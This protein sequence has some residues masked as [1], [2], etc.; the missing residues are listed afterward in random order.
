MFRARCP[1]LCVLLPILSRPALIQ[2]RVVPAAYYIA[3][4]IYEY[5]KYPLTVP[6]RGHGE[7]PMRVERNR[8]TGREAVEVLRRGVT[9]NEKNK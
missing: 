6:K 1:A 3:T 9:G 4:N 8:T 7:I 5:A 2:L